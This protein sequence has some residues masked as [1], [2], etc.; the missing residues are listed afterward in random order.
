MHRLINFDGGIVNSDTGNSNNSVV[1]RDG[2]GNIAVNT[3]NVAS[4]ANTGGPSLGGLAV[5]ASTTATTA[6]TFHEV[7]A[8]AAAVIITLP[9]VAT[10]PNQIF[11][12]VKTDSSA[13]AASYKGSGTETINGANTQSTTTQW[14]VLRVRANAGGTAWYLW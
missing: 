12:L 3:A 11:S 10:V 4:L 14:G 13:N 5:S 1:E 9:P 7:N 8:S 6:N 2:A